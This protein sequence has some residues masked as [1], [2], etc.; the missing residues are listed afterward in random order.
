MSTCWQV[1]RHF[2]TKQALYLL[3]IGC[4]VLFAK[5]ASVLAFLLNV[6]LL[7]VYRLSKVPIVFVVVCV[8][9]FPLVEGLVVRFSQHTWVYMHPLPV[10]RV[11][12]WLFP[13]WGC[14]ALWVIDILVASTMFTH[15]YK[16]RGIF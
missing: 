4:V 16:E 7:C 10:L 8:V 12:L 15:A 14:A 1:P 5:Y 6:I 11:P 2:Y 9:L 3:S 13:L